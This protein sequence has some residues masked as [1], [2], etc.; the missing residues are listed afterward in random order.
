M[1][2]KRFIAGLLIGFMLALALV[3][4]GCTKRVTTNAQTG[5]TTTQQ[6]VTDDTLHQIAAQ[7]RRAIEG[8]QGIGA[9]KRGLFKQ[10]VITAQQSRAVTTASQQALTVLNDINAKVNGYTELDEASRAELKR[11]IAS[12]LSEIATLTGVVTA[13]IHNS[14]AQKVIQTINDALQAAQRLTGGS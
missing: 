8:V 1:K 9:I 13:N 7:I 12:A 4:V 11:L 5:Q 3:P 6:V 14:K 2:L 10:R